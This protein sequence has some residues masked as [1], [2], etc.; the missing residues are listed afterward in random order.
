MVVRE[1]VVVGGRRGDVG[2][3]GSEAALVCA[4]IRCGVVLWCYVTWTHRQKGLRCAN[5]EGHIRRAR[6]VPVR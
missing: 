2:G 3:V 5:W 6:A 1:V 4:V